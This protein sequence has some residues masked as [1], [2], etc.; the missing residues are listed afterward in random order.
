MTPK[1]VHASVQVSTIYSFV[2][3]IVDS[4]YLWCVCIY[5]NVPAL[6]HVSLKFIVRHVRGR[7]Q[8]IVQFRNWC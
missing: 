8:I 4:Y 6:H 7:L 2:L 1:I 3:S 5:H